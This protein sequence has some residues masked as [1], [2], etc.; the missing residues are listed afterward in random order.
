MLRSTWTKSSGGKSRAKYVLQHRGKLAADLLPRLIRPLLLIGDLLSAR[1]CAQERVQPRRLYPTIALHFL[2]ET[3]ERVG[4][5]LHLRM[6]EERLRTSPTRHGKGGDQHVP[7]M[8]DIAAAGPEVGNVLPVSG[9][10]DRELI[11]LVRRTSLSEPANRTAFCTGCRT[12]RRAEVFS[13]ETE[14]VHRAGLSW[15]SGCS[16]YPAQAC[17]KADRA[18]SRLH[19]AMMDFRTG[20][21]DSID[22]VIAQPISEIRGV[23]VRENQNSSR[24]WHLKRAS[25]NRSALNIKELM[26]RPNVISVRR[27]V[28]LAANAAGNGGVFLRTTGARRAKRGRQI[29][30]P[31][32]RLMR[33]SP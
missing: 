8:P 6:N 11:E 12:I 32:F 30:T 10:P 19:R 5:R 22:N 2:N 31:W 18:R 17:R 26:L 20:R 9:E 4:P 1:Q 13:R 16:R 15:R 14:R 23:I 28:I 25:F 29:T 7:K 27:E 24:C 21:Q 3:I 33:G